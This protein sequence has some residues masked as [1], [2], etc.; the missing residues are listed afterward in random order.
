MN[1]RQKEILQSQLNDEKD[2]INKLKKT[3]RAALDDIDNEIARLIGRQDTENLQSII[4]QVEYQKALRGQISGILDKL[5]A[6]QFESISDYLTKCYEQ[7]FLGTMYDL[8]GQN[9]PLIVPIDQKQVIDAIQ[10]ETKLSKPLYDSLGENVSALKKKISSSISRGIASGSPYADIARNIAVGMVGNYKKMSGGALGKAFTI[11]RTEGHRITQKS[12]YDAQTK[13]ISKGADVLKQWDASLDARTRDSHAMVN[14]E[15]REVDEKFS[16]GLLYPGDPS[17]P[18]AEVVNCRCVV[19]QR[20]KWALDEGELA[21]L[22]EEADYFGLDKS[23]DFEDFKEKYLNA[24]DKNGNDIYNGIGRI[25]LQFFASKEKQFGKKLGK[26]AKDFDLDPSNENDRIKFQNIID[27]IITSSDEVRIG[28]WRGQKDEVLFYIRKSDVVITKQTG[29]FITIL[30][31][32][33]ENVRV[34]NARI[35]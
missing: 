33:V 34:K 25:G 15:I 32:G 21:R 24:L 2:V 8:H 18:A 14:G 28:E 16:N 19:T 31:G 7:G 23:K 27:K 6:E 26:H 10:H 1:K 13:A 12:A 4:Y 3:Y 30:K 17:A 35:K 20:A 5:N 11:T 9:I 29:E 22:Q